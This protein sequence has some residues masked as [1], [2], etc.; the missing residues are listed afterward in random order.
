ML[1]KYI[2]KIKNIKE[3]KSVVFIVVSRLNVLLL[4]CNANSSFRSF[5][6]LWIF[7]SNSCFFIWRNSHH[8]STE[9]FWCSLVASQ[10][11]T[12]VAWFRFSSIL[13]PFFFRNFGVMWI[14]FFKYPHLFSFEERVTIIPQSAFDVLWFALL[15]LDS[16]SELFCWCLMQ[17]DCS[18]SAIILQ[19]LNDVNY[20]MNDEFPIDFFWGVSDFEHLPIKH[21]NSITL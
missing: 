17:F 14:F 3:I 2:V 10:F 6:V 12:I 11:F 7:S 16:V 20:F 8:N 15:Q 19:V 13:L 9:L 5:W 18:F 1:E 4:N 21:S